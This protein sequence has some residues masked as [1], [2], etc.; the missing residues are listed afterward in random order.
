MTFVDDYQRR[1]RK[2]NS[3]DDALKDTSDESSKGSFTQAWAKKR[4]IDLNTEKDDEER[5]QR[6]EQQ[7]AKDD[8][9]KATEAKKADWF[10]R[11]IEGVKKAFSLEGAKDVLGDV[12]DVVVDPVV[13]TAVNAVKQAQMGQEGASDYRTEQLL[14]ARDRFADEDLASGAISQVEHDKQKAE[15]K[16]RLEN[17]SKKTK[18]IEKRH[19][20]EY[21]QDAG[22][23]NAVETIAGLDLPYALAKGGAR[24]GNSLLKKFGRKETTDETTPAVSVADDMVSEPPTTKAALTPELQTTPNEVPAIEAPSVPKTPEK[25]SV[26]YT[27]DTAKPRV[28]HQEATEKLQ[29]AGYTTDESIAILSDILPEKGLSMPGSPKRIGLSDESV[30][31]A[32]DDYDQNLVRSDISPED[33]QYISE[34]VA[35]FDTPEQFIDETVERIWNANKKGSGTSIVR[36]KLDVDGI[37]SDA[38]AGIRVS[39][40]SPFYRDY[41]AE[42]GKKPTKQAIRD[43]VE[44][45][46][47]VQGAKG[48]YRDL[49]TEG[50]VSPY[51]SS[52]YSQL[53]ERGASLTGRSNP[54]AGAVTPEGSGVTPLASVDG[55]AEKGTSKLASSVQSKA[56]NEKIISKTEAEVSGLPQYNKANMKQQAEYSTELIKN[57]PQAAVDIA[58]GRKAPPEHILP[59]MVY[60][61]VEDHAM[62]IG[63]E[64]GGKLLKDLANSKQVSDLT[65]MAQNVRAAAERDPHSPVALIND[66]KLARAEAAKK[67]GKDTAKIEKADMKAIEKSTPK[68]TKDDWE[69]FVKE[70]EC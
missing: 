28:T 18:E 1:K 30:M 19:G 44:Q 52:I 22:A 12:K 70:L 10:G 20:R 42:H 37:G 66:L 64:K 14:K 62:K 31:K 43:M 41:F 57:D 59:Q 25:R 36:N 45:R 47:G 13:N 17:A 9:K 40:N 53:K 60:N 5:R 26:N 48:E 68:V 33:S 35:S 23:I 69:T 55:A 15:N 11:G 6:E 8:A 56:V 67:R 29:R 63:G 4:G 3:G 7:K 21:D 39:E 50:E 2:T 49:L 34:K 38:N 46:M 24:V 51:D 27:V 61:A 54:P 58:M 16:T 32:A 65:V